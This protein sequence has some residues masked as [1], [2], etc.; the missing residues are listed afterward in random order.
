MDKNI[1]KTE[2]RY[3]DSSEDELFD[4]YI[5][6]ENAIRNHYNL[7]EKFIE[8]NMSQIN[9]IGSDIQIKGIYMIKESNIDEDA[10]LRGEFDIILNEYF[11]IKSEIISNKKS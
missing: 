10:N 11:K 2:I 8:L 1:L 9:N 4:P 7:K 3:G 6:I 5:L